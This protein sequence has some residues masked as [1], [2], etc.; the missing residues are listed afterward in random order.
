MDLDLIINRVLAWTNTKAIIIIRMDPNRN[1]M[2]EWMNSKIMEIEISHQ[3]WD[4]KVIWSRFRKKK[5]MMILKM[6]KEYLTE[7]RVIIYR[8][9]V[10]HREK[11]INI[12]IIIKIFT[13]VIMRAILV[14]RYFM[15]TIIAKEFKTSLVRMEN[16]REPVKERRRIFAIAQINQQCHIT[17][18]NILTRK[19][20]NNRE[21]F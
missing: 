7:D 21:N 6:K 11:I 16:R 9:L 4:P 1:L 14:M 18:M 13:R 8:L 15:K 19:T 20:G 17:I 5:K 2:K 10:G 12:I 3:R